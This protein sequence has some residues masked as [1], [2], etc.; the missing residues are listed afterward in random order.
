MAKKKKNKAQAARRGTVA[1]LPREERENA[2]EAKEAE[3]AA[4]TNPSGIPWYVYPLDDRHF[5]KRENL[6]KQIFLWVEAVLVISLFMTVAIITS[7]AGGLTGDSFNELLADD[8]SYALLLLEGC[9]QAVVVLLLRDIYK[10]YEI[11]NVGYV[12]YNLMALLV[13]EALMTNVVGI[14]GIVVLIW[15]TW[16]RCQLG[17]NAYTRGVK[18]TGKLRDM[19]GPL[20]LIVAGAFCAYVDIRLL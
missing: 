20:L 3:R 12:F 4:A 5:S 11:G 2:R 16:K 7:L 13:A 18:L 9:L 19:I 10:H 6:N 14:A 1:E 15:R 8:P 17:L